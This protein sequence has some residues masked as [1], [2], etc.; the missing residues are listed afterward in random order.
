[1]GFTV[2]INVSGLPTQ[3]SFTLGVTVLV[4]V[5]GELPV[6]TG[7]KARLPVP[8]LASPMA[9]FEFVQ[10][11]V[12][13]G[14]PINGIETGLPGQKTVAAGA[15]LVNVGGAVPMILNVVSGPVQVIIL[16]EVKVFEP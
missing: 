8:E 10:E 3:L 13:P 12:A 11:N 4:A 9:A 5:A 1:M 16:P 15:G 7:V 6:L 2:I 14:V